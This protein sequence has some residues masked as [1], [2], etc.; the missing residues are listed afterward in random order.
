MALCKIVVVE[1]DVLSKKLFFE[2]DGVRQSS[3][4]S[5]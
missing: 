1:G 3:G 2:A 5:W 4:C